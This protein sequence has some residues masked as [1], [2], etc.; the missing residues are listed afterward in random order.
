AATRSPSPPRADRGRPT[1]RGIADVE[2]TP[3]AAGILAS[4]A[5]LTPSLVPRR[6]WMT[7]VSVATASAAAS[8]VVQVTGAAVRM[9]GRN[10]H[11]GRGRLPHGVAALLRRPGGAADAEAAEPLRTLRRAAVVAAAAG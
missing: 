11:R 9:L 5:A 8:G 1:W 4:W 7:G 2:P 3:L 6:W 10:R